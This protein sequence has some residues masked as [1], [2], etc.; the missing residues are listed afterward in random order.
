MPFAPAPARVPPPA[1]EAFRTLHRAPYLAY[2]RA[3]LPAALAAAVVT[4][5][6][7]TLARHWQTL[8]SSVNPTAD[9]WDHLSHE[10]RRHATPLPLTTPLTTDCVLR[11]DALVL[12]ALGYGPTATAAV[13]GR[14]PDKIR[15]LTRTTATPAPRTAVTGGAQGREEPQGGPHSSRC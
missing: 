8:V 14:D 6:F 11:Y 9:A 1:F 13:T 7:A 3:H 10:V 4:E 15:C 2:A 5:T 12:A